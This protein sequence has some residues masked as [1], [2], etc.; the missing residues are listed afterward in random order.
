MSVSLL[1]P[2]DRAMAPKR[3]DSWVFSGAGGVSLKGECTASA[4]FS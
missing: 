4:C 1:R 3:Q 2:Q